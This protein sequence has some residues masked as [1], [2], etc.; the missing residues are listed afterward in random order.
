MMRAQQLGFTGDE[1]VYILPEYVQNENKTDIWNS[2]GN[3]NDGRNVE[4][5]AAYDSSMFVSNLLIFYCVI[6]IITKF[7][8]R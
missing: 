3:D 2:V 7:S 4:A 6:I 1:W 5:K 8:S